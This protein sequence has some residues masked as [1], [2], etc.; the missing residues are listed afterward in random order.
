MI[1][2]NTGSGVNRGTSVDPRIYEP[3]IEAAE[4][5][6]RAREAGLNEF[7]EVGV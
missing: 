6:V 5:R 4:Q 3:P 7:D 2:A 1:Q